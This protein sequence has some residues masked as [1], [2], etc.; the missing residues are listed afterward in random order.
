MF[1]GNGAD[2]FDVDDVHQWVGWRFDP[3]HFGVGIDGGFDV[4]RLCH[5]DEIDLD[6]ESGIHF[7]QNAVRAAIQVIADDDFIAWIEQAQNRVCGRH[8]AAKAQAELGI[9]CCGQGV[10]QRRARWVL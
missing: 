9:F 10:L 3:H 5:R 1:F 6:A 2:G 8:P 7:G 4:T